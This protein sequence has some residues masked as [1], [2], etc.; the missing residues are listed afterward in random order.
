[1][2]DKDVLYIKTIYEEKS[3]NRAANKLFIAQPSLSQSVHKIE[4]QLGITLFR[5]TGNGLVATHAG[6]KYYETACQMLKAYNNLIASFQTEE[7]QKQELYFGTTRT[8]SSV[9]IK[10]I[11]P[12]FISRHPNI[13]IFI[14]E[15][16][17]KVITK[18]LAQ[19]ELNLA[20]FPEMPS[21]K[22][23]YLYYRFLHEVNL[24]VVA[25]EGL[26]QSA[27]REESALYKVI[28]PRELNDHRY[29]MSTSSLTADLLEQSLKSNEIDLSENI[30]YAT[31]INTTAAMVAVNTDAFCFGI[32]CYIKNEASIE[33]IYTLPKG[34]FPELN[35][36]AVSSAPILDGSPEDKFIQ[37]TKQW[38][39]QSFHGKAD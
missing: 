10:Q 9:I 33:N 22:N 13:K 16:S 15:E 26:F 27:R 23:P 18:M 4:K 35:L 7:D 20:I 6:D 29:I 30:F 12:Q 14:N 19:G 34:F 38:L 37:I 25:K 8:M 21:R 24:V 5:R 2:T 28:D 39:N 1:M 31:N 3:I 11:Y 36:Y 32:D 17:Y